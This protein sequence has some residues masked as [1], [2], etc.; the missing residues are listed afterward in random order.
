VTLSRHKDWVF[1]VSG[2]LI[3]LNFGYVYLIAPKLVPE[4]AACPP[5]ERACEPASRTSRIVLW[6][7]GAIY[8]VGFFSAY[9]LGPLL[10]RFG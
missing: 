1:L 7:S 8:I 9:V 3:T 2:V 5:D 6:V 10:M 4:G